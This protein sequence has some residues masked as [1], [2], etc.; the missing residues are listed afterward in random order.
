MK[1]GRIA[2]LF[3]LSTAGMFALT[4]CSGGDKSDTE[5]D[6]TTDTDGGDDDDADDPTETETETETEDTDTGELLLIRYFGHAG[7]ID[8]AFYNDEEPGDG[9]LLFEGYELA[10]FYNPYYYGDWACQY[11]LPAWGNQSQYD[12]EQCDY[13]MDISG[14]GTYDILVDQSSAAFDSFCEEVVG[15]TDSDTGTFLSDTGWFSRPVGF[16]SSW[17]NDAGTY[18]DVAVYYFGSPYN[19]WYA[20][21]YAYGTDEYFYWLYN[22]TSYYYY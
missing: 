1:L 13:A 17:T 11:A 21:R 12:C 14:G 20:L 6:V 16:A 4:A 19:S 8:M 5:D 10:G 7:A 22:F 3:G 15:V 18:S 9:D 2:M